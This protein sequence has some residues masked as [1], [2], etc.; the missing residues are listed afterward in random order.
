MTKV[1]NCIVQIQT[2]NYSMGTFN[3]VL[4]MLDYSGLIV[5]FDFDF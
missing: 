4:N 5:C 3:Y 1:D 2:I